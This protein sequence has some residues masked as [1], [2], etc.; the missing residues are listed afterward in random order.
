MNKQ[1]IYV[2]LYFE[3]LLGMHNITL[4]L[5]ATVMG[6][7]LASFCLPGHVKHSDVA[8]LLATENNLTDREVLHVKASKEL[9][10]G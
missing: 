9:A 7:V 8:Q 10:A 3:N 5:V 4:F 1:Y 6:H 2:K